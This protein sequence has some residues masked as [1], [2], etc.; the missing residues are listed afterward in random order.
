M[1]ERAKKAK[2]RAGAAPAA[3]A[4]A[5]DGGEERAAPARK[6]AKQPQAAQW[7]RQLL[8]PSADERSAPLRAAS[9]SPRKPGQRTLRGQ[10]EKQAGG[11]RA[12]VSGESASTELAAVDASD[13]AFTGSA[14]LAAADGGKS[15]PT[16]APSEPGAGRGVELASAAPADAA[17]GGRANLA[18]VPSELAVS[19]GP[20]L[21]S[22]ALDIVADG[23]DTSLADVP[24]EL[25]V[26]GDTQLAGAAPA[27]AAD[28]GETRATDALSDVDV[29]GDPQ[30]GSVAAADAADGGET[31]F[32][33]ALPEVAATDRA[34]FEVEVAQAASPQEAPASLSPNER[35]V[36][37]VELALAALEQRGG[38]AYD[39]ISCDCVRALLQRA[40]ESPPRAAALL[41]ERAAVHVQRLAGRF[42]RARAALEARIAA[43]EATFGELP[44]ERAA[45]ARG[46]LVNARRSLRRRACWPA[47]LARL[48]T[49]AP[50]LERVDDYQAASNE[51]VAVSAL[52]RAVDVVPEQAGPYN[53]LRIASDLLERIRAVSPTY[54]SAQL[55]RLEQLAS[56]LALPELPE[57]A[58][59][60]APRK[61]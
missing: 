31:G 8:L 28:D 55:S 17:D 52:A 48:A 41:I 54:L 34:V 25:E 29:S 24:I 4:P 45:C 59:K 38:R 13:V 5:A 1:A 44:E 60:P 40:S 22:A 11:A 23:G 15:P 26:S 56:M 19:G 6:R 27:D 2:A 7:Q 18:A 20:Q 36:Q 51:W 16:D 35:P 30:L 12:A 37:A 33:D 42:D 21:A 53:P 9:T 50:A 47:A 14:T 10:R 61:R 39:A 32:T 49:G 58:P 57:P 3:S 46:E 43:A